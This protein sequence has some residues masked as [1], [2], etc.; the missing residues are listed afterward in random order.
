MPPGIS[1]VL[2]HTATKFQRLHLCFRVKLSSGGTSGFVGRRC[3]LEIQDGS[4]LTGSTD[5]SE[6]IKDYNDIY[7]QHSNE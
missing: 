6:T 5:I 7:H 2:E 1:G 4:Q 3:V